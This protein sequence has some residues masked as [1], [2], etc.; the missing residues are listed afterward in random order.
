MSFFSARTSHTYHQIGVSQAV[1][2]A[3]ETGGVGLSGTE[4]SCVCATSCLWG[5]G[6]PQPWIWT[7]RVLIYVLH[8]ISCGVDQIPT[9]LPPLKGV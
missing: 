5:R 4:R 1:I 8:C 7:V 2:A 9:E 6:K 3:N